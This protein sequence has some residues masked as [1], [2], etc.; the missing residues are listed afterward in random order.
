MVFDIRIKC[1]TCSEVSYYPLVLSRENANR[2]LMDEIRMLRTELKA[3]TE[4]SLNK[5]KAT[6]IEEK[7]KKRGQIHQSERNAR[8]G[9]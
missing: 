4:A 7:A 3:I 8:E 6:A 2:I 9:H 1:P 5:R